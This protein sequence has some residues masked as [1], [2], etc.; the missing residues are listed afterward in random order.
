MKLFG[1]RL[2]LRQLDPDFDNLD[3][4]LGWLRDTHANQ[5][6]ESA[7]EN[8]T[9]Q[10][11]LKYIIEKNS[12]DKAL[13]LGI[14]ENQ[15][16]ALIGTIKLEPIDLKMKTGWVGILIGNPENRGK[17]YGYESLDILLSFCSSVLNLQN[18]YLGVSSNNL[19]A[20]KLYKKLGFTSCGDINNSMSLNIENYISKF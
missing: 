17:G 7:R 4:Y 10:E 8:Y 6:I 15:T 1:K 16:S 19:L 12:S 3:S 2:C 14:F 13:L 18:I 20:L 11:L 5:F 9:K